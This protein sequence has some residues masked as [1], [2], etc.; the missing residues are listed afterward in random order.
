HRRL[1][2]TGNFERTGTHFEWVNDA[3]IATQSRPEWALVLE[4]RAWG[5]FY[6]VPTEF[7]VDGKAIATGPEASWAEFQKIHGDVLNRFNRRYHLQRDDYGALNA[8]VER[9]RLHVLKVEHEHGKD[10]PEYKEASAIFDGEQRAME[11]QRTTIED[12]MH[13]LDSENAR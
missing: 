10:S 5:R 13:A 8:G 3:D 12:A 1:L 4:R 2:R 7:R 9:G 11:T 6:G